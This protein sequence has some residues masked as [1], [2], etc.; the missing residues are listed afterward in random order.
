MHAKDLKDVHDEVFGND[1]G[2]PGL[3]YDYVQFKAMID[4]RINGI[5][6]KMTLCLWLFGLQFVASM[7]VLVKG[8][9][10]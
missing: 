2:K 3:K 7:G 4:G 8:F 5:N 9:M 6:S 10:A 1:A